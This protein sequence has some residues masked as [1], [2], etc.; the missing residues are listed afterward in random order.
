M[1]YVCENPAC[2]ECGKEEY[3]SSETYSFRGERLVGK[4]AD[5]HVCGQERREIKN[6]A[7]NASP[8]EKNIV[9]LKFNM[10]SSEGRREMLKKRSH[11]H[12]EK[13][14]RPVKEEKLRKAVESFKE[15]SKN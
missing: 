4:H 10:A 11:D 15:A 6:P 3:M 2:S 1:K 12:Y 14:V 9:L 8:A 5:C 7:A 13:E